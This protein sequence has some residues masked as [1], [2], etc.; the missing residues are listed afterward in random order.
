[1]ASELQ[2]YINELKD[3]NVLKSEQANHLVKLIQ[4][5]VRALI[6]EKIDEKL[7]SIYSKQKATR[8]EEYRRA[9]SEGMKRHH[10]KLREKA[11]NITNNAL[12][13]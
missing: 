8:S 6:K 10:K 11:S 4:E 3:N 5:H 9:I 12:K 2:T 13:P 1:M 7:A